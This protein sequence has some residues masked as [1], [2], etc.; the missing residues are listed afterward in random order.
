MNGYVVTW[1]VLTW[2]VLTWLVLTWPVLTSQIA[3]RTSHR[4]PQETLEIPSRHF[5]DTLK[6]PSRQPLGTC[7]TP[8]R[9]F[10]NTLQTPTRQSKKFRHVGLFLRLGASCGFLLP[11][12]TN[13]SWVGFAS[14]SGVWQYQICY[15]NH[16]IVELSKEVESL[17]VVWPAISEMIR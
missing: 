3:I 16:I 2:P 11:T 7:H 5:P 6:T 9:Q 15:N 12:P 14:W 1:T 8:S 10:P 17:T 4:Y 13:W